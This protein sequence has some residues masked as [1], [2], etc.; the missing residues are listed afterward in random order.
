MKTLER[1]FVTT[2]GFACC[3]SNSLTGIWRPVSTL[4]TPNNPS[5]H[6]SPDNILFLAD[7]VSLECS[8]TRESEN[9]F[10]CTDFKVRSVPRKVNVDHFRHYLRVSKAGLNFSVQ[11]EENDV[12]KV[13][14]EYPGHS[15][16]LRLKA[17]KETK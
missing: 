2:L 13:T 12:V 15:G 10:R 7:S 5:F 14:W 17:E 4:P 1:F 9:A 3:G 6:V 8:Y 11:H 16:E